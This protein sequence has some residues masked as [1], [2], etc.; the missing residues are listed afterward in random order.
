VLAHREDDAMRAAT[1]VEQLDA[2][3]ARQQAWAWSA[4]ALATAGA[5]SAAAY[6]FDTT[7]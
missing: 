5:A 1:N 4:L 3:Y 7:P 2:A 6:W